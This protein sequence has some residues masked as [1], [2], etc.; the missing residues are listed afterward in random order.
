MGRIY[1]FVFVLL[2]CLPVFSSRAFATSWVLL[3]PQEVVDR[4]EVIV[5]GKYDF[6]SNPVSGKVPFHGLDFKVSKVIKGQNIQPTIIAR[7]DGND[8]GWVDD[9][10][11]QGGELLLFLEKKDSTFLT[12][13]GGTNGMIQVMNGKVDDQSESVRAFY[14]KFLQ[15]EQKTIVNTEQKVR[16]V[17]DVNQQSKEKDQSFLI[18]I[19]FSLAAVLVLIA[20]VTFTR[21]K[22]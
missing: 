18:P 21:R 16:A 5:L 4:A 2:L 13:V 9:F 1:I 11:K 7:I 15:E 20:G 3:D 17:T 14:E 19:I 8:N 6:S 22:T 10:Q 12:P